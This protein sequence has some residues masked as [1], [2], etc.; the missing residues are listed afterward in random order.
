[1]SFFFCLKDFIT[2]FQQTD[3]R[4][5]TVC[6]RMCAYLCGVCLGFLLCFLDLWVY[7]YTVCKIC[8]YCFINYF[9]CSFPFPPVP[10]SHIRIVAVIPHRTVAVCLFFTLSFILDR[11]FFIFYVF[12]SSYLLPFLIRCLSFKVKFSFG[13]IF[14]CYLYEFHFIF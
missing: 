2:P 6:V 9:F 12:K 1:M 8:S 11:S 5:L 4:C 13:V 14:S 7:N 10:T 3:R